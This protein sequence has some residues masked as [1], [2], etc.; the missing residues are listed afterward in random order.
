MEA[1]THKLFA[2]PHPLFLLLTSDDIAKPGGT[3]LLGD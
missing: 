1:L 3:W 2:V